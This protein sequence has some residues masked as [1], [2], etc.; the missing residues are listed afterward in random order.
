[1]S[2]ANPAL[3][4]GLR[5][6][7]LTPINADGSFGTPV[8][9]PVS[10]TLSFSE[11]EEYTELRGDDKLVAIHG[12]GPT[13]SWELDA[14]GISLEAWRVISGGTLT[15]TGS[16]PTQVKSYT[17][18]GLQQRG[19]F[20]I[21]GQSISDSGGDVHAIVHRAKCDDTLEGEFGD[22]NF[23]VTKCSGKGLPDPT[24]DNLYTIVLNETVTSIAAAG[25]NE[26]QNV[27][28][29]ATAGQFKLTYS[30]QTTTD[31]A[32]NASA[33]T[34]QLALEA[35]SNIAVGDVAVSGTL[36]GALSV[37]FTGLL[38]ATNVAQMTAAAGTTPLSGGSASA[39]VVTVQAGG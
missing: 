1:M 23:F 16:T 6:V 8:D 27:I 21:E 22:G 30:G 39:A 11:A 18:K 24:S 31:I 36:P 15:T 20:K 7:R 32:Y 26:V 29:D 37:E 34:V 25:A 2:V 9:L 17:K 14:G 10:Q 35:L 12:Q 38:A 4:Y 5:D 28:V 19:Y 3:P 33:A 13:V